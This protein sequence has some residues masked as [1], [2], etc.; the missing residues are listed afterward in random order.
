ME[1]GRGFR[2]GV[3]T[4]HGDPGKRED[5]D[6]S[7]PE[8]PWIGRGT[9]SARSRDVTLPRSSEEEGGAMQSQQQQTG[10]NNLEYDLFSE[11]HSLLKGNA[12]LEQYIQDAKGVGDTEVES[13]FQTLHDQNKQHVEKLRELIEKR[14][15]SGKAA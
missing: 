8:L 4:S 3:Q 14:I 6:Q 13:C 12:A 10:A 11:I 2:P 5:A 7:P 15:V 9:R 1:A